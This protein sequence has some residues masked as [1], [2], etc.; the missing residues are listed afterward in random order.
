MN[1]TFR[2]F[3]LGTLCGLFVAVL[4]FGC[5][6]TFIN[7]TDNT[8]FAFDDGFNVGD[9]IPIGDQRTYGAKGRHPMV[10]IFT[11]NEDGSFKKT[12]R[13]NQKACAINDE[14]KIV[15]LSTVGKDVLN[16]DIYDEID[17]LT[18]PEIPPCC[19]HHDEKAAMQMDEPL[20][21]LDEE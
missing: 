5:P 20:S 4:I 14:D 10:C 21:T 17:L 18:N 7:D 15:H 11:Q 8:V 2:I 13:V 12:Y 16:K 6:I 1:T 9:V 19:A 3:F